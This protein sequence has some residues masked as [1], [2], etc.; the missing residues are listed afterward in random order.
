MTLN[1][2]EVTEET[3]YIPASTKSPLSPLVPTSRRTPS[4]PL[5]TSSTESTSSSSPRHRGRLISFGSPAIE[6]HVLAPEE[7][8][9]V[10]VLP[11]G[12]T[13]KHEAVAAEQLTTAEVEERQKIVIKAVHDPRPI[14]D[15][16]SDGELG[17]GRLTMEVID[18]STFICQHKRYKIKNVIR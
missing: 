14:S 15:A 4:R 18:A 13:A 6:Q 12:V 3:T 5:S 17:P 8:G 16:G 7:T 10:P 11:G 1:D 2:V 9:T